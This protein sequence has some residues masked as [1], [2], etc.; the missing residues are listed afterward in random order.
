MSS[1]TIFSV[2]FELAKLEMKKQ[3]NLP[4]KTQKLEP[5]QPGNRWCWNSSISWQSV[6]IKFNCQTHNSTHSGAIE[7]IATAKHQHMTTIRG[8]FIS[9]LFFPAVAK[10]KLCV[11]AAIQSNDPSLHTWR[12]EMCRLYLCILSR[13]CKKHSPQKTRLNRH[14][15]SLPASKIR[16]FRALSIFFHALQS[17]VGF[18]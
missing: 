5:C 1:E 3:R 14:H 13:V 10:S 11:A 12:W 17:R 18:D 8:F 2:D 16:E 4:E 6:E 9:L 7:Q 15:F